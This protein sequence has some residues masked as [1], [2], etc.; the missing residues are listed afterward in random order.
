MK[1]I[2]LISL[3]TVLLIGCSEPVDE[4]IVELQIIEQ[5]IKKLTPELIAHTSVE[6]IDGEKIGDYIQRI[7]SDTSQN[8]VGSIICLS[9]FL[10]VVEKS[11]RA[12]FKSS[13]DDDFLDFLASESNAEKKIEIGAVLQMDN[14]LIDC[15]NPSES[16]EFLGKLAYSRILFSEDYRNARFMIRMEYGFSSRR[17]VV[18]VKNKAPQG[19]EIGEFKWGIEKISSI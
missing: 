14:R 10:F 5:T 17:F 3:L 18:R 4:S 2:L 9:D 12:F 6:P 7:E 15:D 13:V 16:P 8:A 11:E 1:T 19:S